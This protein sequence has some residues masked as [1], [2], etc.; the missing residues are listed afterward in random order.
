M[1]SILDLEKMRNKKDIAGLIK[2][3]D[4]NEDKRIREK[5]AYIL[6]DIDAKEAV[7]PLIKLLND[8][9]WPIRK[10]A[11]LSLGRIGDKNAVEPLTDVK[12]TI[13]GM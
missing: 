6:G 2:V 8:E 9:Y 5:A 4:V 13:T 1:S 7:E 10:A 3:L 11:A 12:E